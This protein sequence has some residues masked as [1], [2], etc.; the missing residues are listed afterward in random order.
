MA[1]VSLA[2]AFFQG[3]TARA[4]PGFRHDLQ[5]TIGDFLLAALANPELAEGNFGERPL[6]RFELG[7]FLIFETLVPLQLLQRLREFHHLGKSQPVTE[8]LLQL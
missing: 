5:P 8:R 3:L 2:L 6:N 7:S 4:E 1:S